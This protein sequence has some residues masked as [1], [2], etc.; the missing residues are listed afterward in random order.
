MTAAKFE[1]RRMGEKSGS[2]GVKLDQQVIVSENGVQPLSTPPFKGRW[3]SG[4]YV[5]LTGFDQILSIR[6]NR[7]HKMTQDRIKFRRHRRR[8]SVVDVN[9]I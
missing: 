4:K 7:R 9:L 1:T 3:S 2:I 8:R 6:P 5:Q